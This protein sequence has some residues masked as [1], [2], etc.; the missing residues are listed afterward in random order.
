MAGSSPVISPARIMWISIG[1][2]CF[3]AD[4]ARARLTP[5]RTLAL[6]CS[7]SS[8]MATFDSVSRLVSS[9]RRIG[10]PEPV[11][12]ASV[13]AKRAVFRLRSNLP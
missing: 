13:L 11:V 10:T 12:M 7:T 8:F 9:A 5:S 3:C 6:A 4:S 2:K 1:G